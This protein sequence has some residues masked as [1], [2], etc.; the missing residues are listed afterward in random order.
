MATLQIPDE[1]DAQ[2]QQAADRLGCT[3]V[4]FLHE[5]VTARLEEQFAAEPEFTEE[6]I[7]RMKHSIA[8]LDRGEVV[9]SEQVDKM[10]EDWRAQRVSR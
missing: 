1:L 8:Q 10:F 9:T 2:L 7:A 6:Q 4:D 5:A 3:K